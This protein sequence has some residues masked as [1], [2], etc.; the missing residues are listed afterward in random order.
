MFGESFEP[1]ARRAAS[2]WAAPPFQR[3]AGRRAIDDAR[4]TNTEPRETTMDRNRKF[5]RQ[6]L[7]AVI[8]HDGELSAIDAASLVTWERVGYPTKVGHSLD[9]LVDDGYL[10]VRLNEMGLRRYQI[11]GR[12]AARVEVTA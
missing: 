11:A 7:A 9:R 3:P 2:H 8:S 6:V 10:Q 4:T 1:T 12:L 5:D